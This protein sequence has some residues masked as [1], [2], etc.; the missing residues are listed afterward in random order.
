MVTHVH[1]RLPIHREYDRALDELADV[2]AALHRAGYS[3]PGSVAQFVDQLAAER[4]QARAAL[5]DAQEL[6]AT[7]D[8]AVERID[9][10]RAR[11]ATTRT[12]SR[13]GSAQG[14]VPPAESHAQARVDPGA[15]AMGGTVPTAHSGSVDT[16]TGL[17]MGGFVPS[18]TVVIGRDDR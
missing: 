11:Y 3:D 9:R 1:V 8:D 13:P 15:D 10:A 16:V 14:A 7:L 18:G 17:R 12:G 2:S 4:D 6:I 5:G